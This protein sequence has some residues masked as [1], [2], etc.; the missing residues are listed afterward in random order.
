MTIDWRVRLYDR[1]GVRKCEGNWH[2]ECEFV[3]NDFGDGSFEIGRNDLNC[4]AENL[5]FGG[6][7]VFDHARAGAWGGVLL[8]KRAWQRDAL[9][10]NVRG[11]GFQWQRRIGPKAV[12]WRGKAGSI[13]RTALAFGN[14]KQDMRIEEGQIFLGGDAH[15]ETPHFGKLLKS[16][17]GLAARSGQDWDIRPIETVMADGT[18]HLAFELNWYERLGVDLS[19]DF[20]LA[21]GINMEWGDED[22]LIEEPDIINSATV[23]G[24]GATNDVQPD[25]TYRDIA[26]MDEYGLSEDS[27]SYNSIAPAT[28]L[29]NAR[30]RV[31]PKKDPLRTYKLDALDVD[32]TWE[33]LREGN[34]VT[35]NAPSLGFRSESPIAIEGSGEFGSLDKV[36]V[37]KRTLKTRELR[38]PLLVD[39]VRI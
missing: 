3:L 27:A 23:Y 20:T 21:E 37:R 35:L 2:Y 30:Q 8:G 19:D 32:D 22:M 31:V 10:V 38:M 1:F 25:Q 12:T 15:E 18:R 33:K 9:V 26:S 5:A 4:T 11:I 34:I 28:L 13:I 24:N 39:Q 14:Q 7:A 6:F 16:V 36:R 17:R 29:A